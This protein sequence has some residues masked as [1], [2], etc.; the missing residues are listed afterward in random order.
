M[1]HY[2]Q[3][4]LAALEKED[5]ADAQ[6]LLEK[7]L[8]NDPADLLME[9]GE[10]LFSLGFLEDA[11]KVFKHLLNLYP[12]EDSLKID[13]AQIAIENDETDAAFEYLEDIEPESEAYPESLLV[14][15][16]LYQVLG[17]PEVSEAK[18]KKAQEYLPK[19]PLLDFALAELYY[20]NDQLN[21]A[22]PLY[23]RLLEVED[24]LAADVSLTERLGTANS[25]LGN[26]EVAAEYLEKAVEEERTEDNLFQLAITYLQIDERERAI[27]LLQQ[28]RALNPNYS[29]LYLYLG[30]ALEEEER[31]EEAREVLAAGIKENPYQVE[32]YHLAAENAFRMHYSDKSEELLRRALELGEDTDQTILSLSHLLIHE[33]R[34]NDALTELAKLEEPIPMADW[35]R[36]QAYEQLEEFQKAG[37]FYKLAYPDFQHDPEFL[38]EYGLFLR[39]E[40]QLEKAADILSHYLLH[41]PDDLEVQMILD[42]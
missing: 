28:L 20:S 4:M 11:Q 31:L 7:A 37:E 13:L 18:L 36:A 10:R 33:E 6:I 34:F 15:A 1:D 23:E 25:M 22:I 24:Q 26:F 42:E 32:L 2:S 38:K 16:D 27:S 19:E 5:L 3:K 30:D 41:V 21:E 35:I 9:L 12:E 8:K 29:S 14:L 40:G 39:E 17:I